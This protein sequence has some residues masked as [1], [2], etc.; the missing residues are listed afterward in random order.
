MFSPSLVEI[1][2]STQYLSVKGKEKTFN[3]FPKPNSELKMLNRAVL[4]IYVDAL[5]I[6]NK[7]GDRLLY[8]RTRV[9][10]GIVRKT[11][12]NECRSSIY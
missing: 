8:R 1:N 11:F 10:S 7:R 2:M 9:V 12:I 5:V 3:L 4:Y 6:F